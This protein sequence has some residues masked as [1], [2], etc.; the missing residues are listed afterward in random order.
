[1][2]TQYYKVNKSRRRIDFLF[3]L[4]VFFIPVSI[5]V[6]IYQ[7]FQSIRIWIHLFKKL[8]NKFFKII[9]F[10]HKNAQRSYSHTDI[11]A[12]SCRVVA[13]RMR[14]ANKTVSFYLPSS[15][16]NF[17]YLYKLDKQA[18]RNL[19][20]ATRQLFYVYISSPFFKL[21]PKL[22]Y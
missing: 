4:Q 5:Q 16:A 13:L 7:S 11:V 19:I 21:C 10:F 12:R 18:A 8:L 22:A 2:I 20:L 15:K 6:S 3:Y 17:N 9:H 1:M 14:N